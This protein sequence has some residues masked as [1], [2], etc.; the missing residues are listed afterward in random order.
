VQV[1]HWA[2]FV[3]RGSDGV[4][5]CVFRK[6]AYMRWALQKSNTEEAM[7]IEGCIESN[8][9]PFFIL[10]DIGRKKMTFSDCIWRDLWGEVVPF[11]DMSS[12]H[13]LCLVTSTLRG[14][15]LQ[16]RYWYDTLRAQI[17]ASVLSDDELLRRPPNE[18]GTWRLLSLIRWQLNQLQKAGRVQ[19][20]IDDPYFQKSMIRIFS[21][22][23]SMVTSLPLPSSDEFLLQSVCII[24]DVM[25]TVVEGFWHPVRRG[26]AVYLPW[27]PTLRD[28]IFLLQK[29]LNALRRIDVERR[30]YYLQKAH[31]F[32]TVGP[33]YGDHVLV[34]SSSAFPSY[35]DLF[36][37]LQ[38]HFDLLCDNPVTTKKGLSLL[39]GADVMSVEGVYRLQGDSK[40]LYTYMKDEDI[41]LW[42]AYA[43]R[44]L[45]VTQDDEC[46]R[47]L[48]VTGLPSPRFFF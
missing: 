28:A 40:I 37:C 3:D 43:L 1:K 42:R 17:P 8:I 23:D 21:I 32:P 39:M 38:H 45:A 9:R 14:I 11:C 20:V 30:T 29:V 6:I 26:R 46:C 44:V 13:R 24:N 48:L 27:I 19:V 4:G 25:A 41:S 47:Q 35:S 12:K 2:D 33:P 22:F 5:V 15:V 18:K 31:I 10:E 7:S 34:V 36:Y 16:N